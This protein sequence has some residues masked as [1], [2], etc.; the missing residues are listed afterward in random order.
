MLSKFGDSERGTEKIRK[1]FKMN[2]LKG[3]FLYSILSE[4][5]GKDNE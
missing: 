3:V 2:I 5:E 4:M 1:G